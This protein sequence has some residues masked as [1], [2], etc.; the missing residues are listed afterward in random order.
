MDKHRIVWQQ[1]GTRGS[2]LA[3]MVALVALAVLGMASS[4][5]L[6]TPGGELAVFGQCPIGTAGLKGCIV[7]RTESGEIKI[8]NTAVPIVS[9][10]TLQGGFGNPNPETGQQP[11]YGAKN[12]ETLSRTPQSVPGGLLSLAKCEEAKNLFVRLACKAI[13][14]SRLAS[15]NATLELAVPA[16]DIYF[17]EAMLALQAP[18]PPYPPALVLPVQIKLENVLLGNQCYIGSS[19]E[20]IILS[21]T[22]GTTS[23]P[24]PNKPINGNPGEQTSRANGEILVSKHS[25]IVAN[26]F[27]VPKATGCGPL[28]L[29]D[30]II[31]T[32]LGLPSAAGNN[33]AILTSTVEQAGHDAIE[34]S[35]TATT[36][37][38]PAPGPRHEHHGQPGEK[39]DS[40][41]E[42]WNHTPGFPRRP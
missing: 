31:N 41:S 16:S 7:S 11:F 10:Q 29:L 18:F 25:T 2:R 28:G 32:K 17:N 1:R 33:T 15:V 39:Q 27:P 38:S 36:Q 6:A 23:P 3:G 30:N 35:E 40:T 8:G 20:P 21:F 37:N 19:T 22:S 42:E 34:E 4:V 14:T 26:A 5:A 24:P 13:S 9:P 12:G